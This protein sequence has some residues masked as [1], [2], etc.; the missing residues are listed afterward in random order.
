MLTAMG[1]ELVELFIHGRGGRTLVRILVDEPGGISIRRVSQ[2]SRA[3]S[4]LLDQKDLIPV[5]YTL[6][7]SSPGVDR[8]LKNARDFIRHAGRLVAIQ[9]Q[10]GETTETLVGRIRKADE[11][12]VLL[13]IEKDMQ[14]KIIE[15]GRIQSAVVLL[16][17]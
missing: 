14:E 8:P 9:H 7:V 2:A 1:I 15:L 12:T 4:D 3:I 10:V 6:E 13:T 17:F 16:E 5:R 11:E